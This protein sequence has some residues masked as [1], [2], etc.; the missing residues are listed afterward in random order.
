MLKQGLKWFDD[1]RSN[2]KG[3]FAIDITIT[4]QVDIIEW[5]GPP[6]IPNINMIDIYINGIFQQKDAYLEIGGNSIRYIAQ[7]PLQENDVVSIRYRPTG[8]NFGNIKILSSKGELDK[9]KNPPIGEVALV[10]NEKAFYIYNE[11]GKWEKIIE[12]IETTDEIEQKYLFEVDI[13]ISNDNILTRIIEWE[14]PEYIMDINMLD[15]YL[16]GIL[17]YRNDFEELT[18]NSILYKRQAD[19]IES[20]IITI[21]YRYTKVNLGNITVIENPSELIHI[22]K[23]VLGSCALVKKTKKIYQYDGIEWK[24]L[25]DLGASLFE[26][27]AIE[28]DTIKTFYNNDIISADVKISNKI[29]NNLLKET[30]G[31]YVS[32]ASTN[33][34]NTLILNNI[35]QNQKI[36]IQKDEKDYG[37]DSLGVIKIYE[38]L[39]NTDV[40]EILNDYST[41]NEDKYIYDKD[42]VE[43]TPQGATLKNN[44][45]LELEYIRDLEDGYKL[46]KIDVDLSKYKKILI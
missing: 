43:F 8:F 6:Y 23:P 10:V 29:G 17:L 22:Y 4:D 32:K 16:N 11:D 24:F 38:L 30:D 25:I 28:T 14:G 2:G 5:E 18:P 35:T 31:L 36:T 7:I 27:E 39:Q 46:Y 37:I 1:V 21:K 15:V 12:L 45:T 42:S 34:F 26:I 3:F 13:N 20:D 44:D 40:S 19:L 9:I 41:G 33:G